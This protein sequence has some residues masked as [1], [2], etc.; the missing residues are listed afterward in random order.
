MRIMANFCVFG[1]GAIENKF[2]QPRLAKLMGFWM[3]WREVGHD[4]VVLK[5]RQDEL[6]SLVNRRTADQEPLLL[7]RGANGVL[8]DT[9]AKGLPSPNLK[10]D[11]LYLRREVVRL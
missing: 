1:P 4:L 6:E 11:Y 8:M 3:L 7:V 9:H 2:T 5:T 10:P